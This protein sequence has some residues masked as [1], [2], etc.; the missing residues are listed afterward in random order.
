MLVYLNGL[1]HCQV[2]TI[3]QKSDITIKKL[4]CLEVCRVKVSFQVVIGPKSLVFAVVLV[5][6]GKAP[7]TSLSVLQD[8]ILKSC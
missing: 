1:T 8:F 7:L 3:F 4:Q 6:L 2:H 5:A